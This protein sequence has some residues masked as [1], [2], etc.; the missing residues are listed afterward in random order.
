MK[1][2]GLV[3]YRRKFLFFGPLVEWVEFSYEREF[4]I[5][6]YNGRTFETVYFWK[7]NM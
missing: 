4:D 7:R 5:D 3:K 2:T 1:P 6:N